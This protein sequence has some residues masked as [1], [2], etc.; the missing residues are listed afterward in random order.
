LTRV[1]E[2]FG[3]ILVIVGAEFIGGMAVPV[4]AGLSVYGNALSQAV[5]IEVLKVGMKRAR[6]EGTRRV[7]P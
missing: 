3:G 2:T 7:G 5:G 6:R 4:T 1:L